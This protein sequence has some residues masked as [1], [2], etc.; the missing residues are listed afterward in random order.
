MKCFKLEEIG[1]IVGIVRAGINSL[2]HLAL[3][4]N[5]GR[6]ASN[7]VPET[8]EETNSLAHC[9][10]DK[11][12]KMWQKGNYWDREN[13]VDKKH[14]INAELCRISNKVRTFRF[15]SVFRLI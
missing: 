6:S 14:V 13:W 9:F 12:F 3:V 5:D 8:L 15:L 10:D 4:V 2:F 11:S 1:R 7:G